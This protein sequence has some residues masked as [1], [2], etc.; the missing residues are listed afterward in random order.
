VAQPQRS[1]R[2]LQE[3]RPQVPKQ[4]VQKKPKEVPPQGLGQPA[5]QQQENV[6]KG[7]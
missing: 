7:R 2:Q 4:K 6:Q 1:K 3:P 5:P